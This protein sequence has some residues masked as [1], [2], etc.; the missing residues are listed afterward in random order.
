MLAFSWVRGM[1]GLEI[2][3]NRDHES[4]SIGQIAMY[5]CELAGLSPVEIANRIVD[6]LNAHGLVPVEL[7][8]LE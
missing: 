8:D 7:T 4:V 5:R 6:L 2:L 3:Y 1:M